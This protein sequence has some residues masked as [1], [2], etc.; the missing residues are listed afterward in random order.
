MG[1]IFG[2]LIIISVL[3]ITTVSIDTWGKVQKAEAEA[4]GK[5]SFENLANELKEDNA[6]LKIKLTIIEEK[7][8]SIDKMLKE[9]E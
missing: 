6:Y 2:V 7:L 3:I 4:V 5:K 9:V 1:F 8:A